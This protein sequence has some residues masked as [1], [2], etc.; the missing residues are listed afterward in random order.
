MHKHRPL[1]KPMMIVTT[2]GHIVKIMGPYKGKVN[3]AS[4]VTDDLARAVREREE[5][6]E[7]DQAAEEEVSSDEEVDFPNRDPTEA[8]PDPDIK[9]DAQRLLD[10]QEPNDIDVLDRGYRDAIEFLKVKRKLTN[11]SCIMLK[12][13]Y[14]NFFIHCQT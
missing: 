7:W 3:D 8:W 14:F 10:Y 1:A 6:E 11:V 5:R 4:I 9:A 13:P 2:T 12:D